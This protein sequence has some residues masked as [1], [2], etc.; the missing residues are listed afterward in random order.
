[1]LTFLGSRV[2][3]FVTLPGHPAKLS[4]SIK[5]LLT[6]AKSYVFEIDLVLDSIYY[7]RKKKFPPCNKN[8][9]NIIKIDIKAV[10][11]PRI[12]NVSFFWLVGGTICRASRCIQE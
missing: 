12:I 1:M 11:K 2:Y 8:I 4:D 9:S 10:T 5:L 7:L 3:L 6:D